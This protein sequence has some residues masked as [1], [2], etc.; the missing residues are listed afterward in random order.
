MQMTFHCNVDSSTTYTKYHSVEIS[1]DK[2]ID[3]LC[4]AASIMLGA[5]QSTGKSC[6]TVHSRVGLHDCRAQLQGGH[7]EYWLHLQVSCT[8]GSASNHHGKDASD[9]AGQAT[10]SQSCSAVCFNSQGSLTCEL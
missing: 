8:V 10:F 7:V 5:T 3:R 4:F 2:S 9:H 6:S 1:I